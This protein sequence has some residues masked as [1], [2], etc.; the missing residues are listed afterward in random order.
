MKLKSSLYLRAYMWKCVASRKK[1]LLNRYLGFVCVLRTVG[2][3]IGTVDV[4]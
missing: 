1:Y 3:N 4:L 2:V